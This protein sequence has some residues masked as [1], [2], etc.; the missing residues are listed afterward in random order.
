MIETCPVIPNLV[1]LVLKAIR[2]E[3]GVQSATDLVRT[4]QFKNDSRS[5]IVVCCTSWPGKIPHV[6]AFR[7]SSGTTLVLHSPCTI[8]QFPFLLDSIAHTLL[9]AI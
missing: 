2:G 8:H 1:G 3:R 7:A 9:F 4:F 5:M 6:T